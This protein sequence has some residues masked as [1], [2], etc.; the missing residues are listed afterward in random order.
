MSL[1][2]HPLLCRAAASLSNCKCSIRFYSYSRPL[3]PQAY[4]C[5]VSNRIY[6]DSIL[7]PCY[8][9]ECHL[10]TEISSHNLIAA[11]SIALLSHKYELRISLTVTQSYIASDTNTILSLP[12]N[13]ARSSDMLSAADPAMNSNHMQILAQAPSMNSS[14]VVSKVD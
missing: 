6:F 10:A 14:L 4:P 7:T 8:F 12:T 1:S 13:H 3:F 2:T 9:C 11:S 5:L